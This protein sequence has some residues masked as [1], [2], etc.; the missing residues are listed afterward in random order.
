MSRME[1]DRVVDPLERKAGV[2]VGVALVV[3]RRPFPWRTRPWRP[4]LHGHRHATLRRACVRRGRRGVPRRSTSCSCVPRCSGRPC[5]RGCLG[6]SLLHAGEPRRVS[7][8]PGGPVRGRRPGPHSGSIASKADRQCPPGRGSRGCSASAGPGRV[9]P[10]PRTASSAWRPSTTSSS[11]PTG[12]R[13]RSRLDPRLIRHLPR[14]EGRVSS[15]RAPVTAPLSG[16][17]RRPCAARSPDRP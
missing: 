15:D 11:R 13:P 16:R 3:A 5:G 10:S 14:P 8:L 7:V 6:V 9:R 4:G 2:G 17:G 1:S 12:T